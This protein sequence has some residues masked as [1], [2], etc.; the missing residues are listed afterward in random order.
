MGLAG[1]GRA[2]EDDVA[3]FGEEA[4]SGE[5]GEARAEDGGEAG[6]LFGG[7]AI[8]TFRTIGQRAL[9]AAGGAAA[10]IL[11]SAVSVL[12]SLVLVLFLTLLILAESGDWYRVRL[13]EN[14][15]AQARIDGGEGYIAKSLVQAPDASL[16]AATPTQ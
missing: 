16:P 13:G 3:C 9:G 1:A 4:A 12:A 5:G 14:V 7:S 6:Q 15:S 2:E 10:A 11:N 8:E